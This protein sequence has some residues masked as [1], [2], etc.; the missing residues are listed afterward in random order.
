VSIKIRKYKRTAAYEVDI[1]TL[2]VDGVP[3][4]ERLKSPVAS[5]EATKRWGMEREAHLALKHGIG[6]CRCKA[7]GE[8][9]NG[10]DPRT[11]RVGE[12]VESFIKQRKA[13]GIPNA[14]VE[15]QR[16]R[17]HVLPVLRSLRVGDVRPRDAYKLVKAVSRTESNRGGA[18]APRTV[19]QVFFTA[20]QVF[21]Y[22]VLQ[23]IIPGNPMVLARG[24][25]PRVQDKDPSWRARAVFT[26]TEVEMV[27]S[28]PR[29]A[30][31][32]RV[33]YAIEFLTGL[34]TGQVSALR[35]SDYDQDVEPLG[36]LTSAIS[37]NSVTKI[38]KATKTGV[39]HEV[40]VHPTLAKVLAVWK[41]TGW[42][43]WMKKVATPG[44]LIIPNINGDNRDV[45]KALEDFHEDLERLGLR[46][47][48]HYDARRTFISL[49]VD[50]GGS[51]E[52]LRSITHPRPVDAF[53]L[54]RTPAWAAKCEAV[55][56]LNVQL[57][58]GELVQLKQTAKPAGTGELAE[59]K[60]KSGS[61]DP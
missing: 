50:A 36:R 13:E 44:D 46:K 22:A 10:P 31:H 9:D 25:L 17:D 51:K 15:E 47:R 27:I 1:N 23:E 48:R 34:R 18:L 55:A 42:R 41:L 60:Q 20:R 57:R 6:G 35:W 52:L 30:P 5:K 21:Q 2:S 4:R 14:V 61:T 32:R 33:A 59:T 19:R 54:Y 12:L 39:T 11:M 8:E 37:Y 38:E 24:V 3:I 26:A 45:R 29:I 16:L 49:G 58:E 28:D 43:K 56:K 53:D 40:P 7:N